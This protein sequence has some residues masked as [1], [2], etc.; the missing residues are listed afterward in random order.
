MLFPSFSE[1]WGMPLIETQAMGTPVICSDIPVFHEA[2]SALATFINPL[3]AITWQKTILDFSDP[4]KDVH[5]VAVKA[6]GSYTPPRWEDH[7]IIL[8]VLLDNLKSRAA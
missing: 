7:F 6:L 3:D 4:T 2:S 1:G 5:D 8:D